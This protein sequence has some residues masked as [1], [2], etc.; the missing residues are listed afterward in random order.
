MSR[1]GRAYPNNTLL[2]VPQPVP[3]VFDAVGA[4]AHANA[5]SLSWSHVIAGNC[6]LTVVGN[7]L[8]S[9]TPATI[10]AQ[11]GST[12]M[13][14]LGS[15]LNFYNNTGDY[16][17]LYLFGL[18]NGPT[19]TQTV[20]I[21]S[22]SSIFAAANS[23]SYNNVVGFGPVA[24]NSAATSSASLTVSGPA[25]GMTVAAFEGWTTNFTAF[26]KNSRWNQAS[27]SGVNNSVVIGDTQG[28]ATFT[29]TT[30][31]AWGGIGVP[32]IP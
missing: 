12:A 17:S 24:T 19:G 18:L 32:L 28:S 10:I 3:V 15:N 25:L 7:V 11:V 31:T 5:A 27:N 6:V 16:E 4:G 26:N 1:L 30:A 29:A 13:T 14:L 21:S 2:A 9:S 20:S 23:V 22:T 8:V